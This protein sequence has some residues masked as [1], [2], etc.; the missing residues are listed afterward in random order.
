MHQASVG[1]H[2]PECVKGTKQKVYTR[3]T[4]P[5][6]QSL[7]TYVFIGLNLAVFIAQLAFGA[8]ISTAGRLGGHFATWGPAIDAS[9]QW[10]R[11]FTGGFLHIGAFHLAMN[12]YSLYIIGPIIEKRL[13]S[14][15][16]VL[17]YVASL[18]GGSFGALL[19]DPARGV[20]GASGAI[21]GL[22]GLLVLMFRSRGI[23]INQSGLGPVLLLNLFISLSGFVSLGGHAGGFAVGLALGAM[24]FGTAPGAKPVFGRDEKKPDIAT[25]ALI[26]ILFV[27]C[28]FAA[29]RWVGVV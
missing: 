16:Y 24:Y 10:W 26:A 27:G 15:S 11:I 28:L 8:S 5:G 21:F 13:G 18:V 14:R 25:V 3:N 29:T 12:M 7:A 1:V 17:A 9:N 19:L 20:M 22:L 2:C 4:M 23:S 6:A